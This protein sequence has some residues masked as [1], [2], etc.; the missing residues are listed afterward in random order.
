[1]PRKEGWVING[2]KKD[3]RSPSFF[4]SVLKIVA[5]FIVFAVRSERTITHRIKRGYFSMPRSGEI[6]EP[7]A[8]TKLVRA[9]AIHGWVRYKLA[10][11]FLRLGLGSGATK[12]A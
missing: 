9:A 6:A 5:A 2:K 1:V 10:I 7:L 12:T 3:G 8:A 4:F 11:A